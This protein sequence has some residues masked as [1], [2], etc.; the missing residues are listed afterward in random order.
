MSFR[1][2]QLTDCHLFADKCKVVSEGVLRSGIASFKTLALVLEAIR[3]Y[4]PDLVLVTGDLI[5][6][7]SKWSYQHFNN[8]WRE[9]NIDVQLK[10]IP[11]N[12]DNPRLMKE[13]FPQSLSLIHI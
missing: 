3:E 8:L 13:S 4:R 12:H 7:E 2:I 11:G 5:A 10:V 1:V 6:D 9:V